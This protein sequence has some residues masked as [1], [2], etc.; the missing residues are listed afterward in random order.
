MDIL[1]SGSV[2]LKPQNSSWSMEYFWCF[3]DQRFPLLFPIQTSNPASASRKPRLLLGWFVTQLLASPNNPC[4]RNT[5]GLEAEKKAKSKQFI[6]A[7]IF[8]FTGC[9]ETLLSRIQYWDFFPESTKF[10]N[11]TPLSVRD[12]F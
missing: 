6:I 7:S 10:K 4:W 2:Y 9:S 8:S 12:N 11:K 5:A 3:L 1:S